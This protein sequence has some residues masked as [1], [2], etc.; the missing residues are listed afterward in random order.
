MRNDRH[1][2]VRLTNLADSIFAVAMT[3]LAYTIQVS[4]ARTRPGRQL[5]STPRRYAAAIWHSGA[6]LFHCWTSLGAAL[7]NASR[8]H[9]R[10]RRTIGAKHGAAIRHRPDSLQR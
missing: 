2:F 9:A 6:K 5:G 7:Q 10:G 3:F 1:D 8:N 4:I